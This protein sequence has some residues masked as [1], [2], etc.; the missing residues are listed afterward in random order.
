MVSKINILSVS[1]VKEC[2]LD[3]GLCRSNSVK[4]RLLRT[5]KK[6]ILKKEDSNIKKTLSFANSIESPKNIAS[7]DQIYVL[8]NGD[9][10]MTSAS[11]QFL[12]PPYWCI[13]SKSPVCHLSHQFN[14]ILDQLDL[15]DNKLKIGILVRNLS[16]EKKVAVRITWSGWKAWKDYPGEFQCS[17]VE[18]CNEYIGVDRFTALLN[19]D[20]LLD[21]DTAEMEFAI[22]YN[23]NNEEYWDNNGT[24]NYRVNFERRSK[25]SH[26]TYST[27]LEKPPL[28]L[29]H[30]SLA[31][32]SFHTEQ[33][34]S[35]ED[36]L[37]LQKY[38]L[39]IFLKQI[40]SVTRQVNLNKEPN[41]LYQ[42]R[43]VL[44]Q[45]PKDTSK[46]P[47]SP[48]DEGKKKK[49][50]KAKKDPNAPKKGLS[51]FM[52]YSQENRPRIKE[53]N[54][55]ATFGEM[56]KLLGNAWKE[57]NE[58]DKAEY[59]DKAAKDKERYE[60]EMAEYKEK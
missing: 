28:H 57:L 35:P 21:G 48:T 42:P 18:T 4:Q 55:N 33:S 1:P 51:A 20:E 44:S 16:F 49:T 15:K 32:F 12:I 31:G 30:T 60:S 54:P 11:S 59:T 5:P 24:K 27:K 26:L 53:E 19:L 38:Q 56:G 34:S 29:L 2:P 8:D 45:M 58:E 47:K 40:P 3:R 50:T 39:P 52:I 46:A 9:E 36:E 41:L 23:V 6:S 25:P 43:E 7:L 37:P 22:K 13:E 17:V 14:V 10:N